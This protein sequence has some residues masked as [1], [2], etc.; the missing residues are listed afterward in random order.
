MPI[1]DSNRFE[2]PTENI[3]IVCVSATRK[4]EPDRRLLQILYEIHFKLLHLKQKCS[5]DHNAI[6]LRQMGKVFLLCGKV[7]METADAKFMFYLCGADRRDKI[8]YSPKRD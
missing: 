4:N 3:S 7:E 1:C 2:M 5:H 8:L 6:L